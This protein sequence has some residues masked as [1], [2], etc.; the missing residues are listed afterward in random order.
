MLG[1]L[2]P[3]P[4]SPRVGVREST[5]ISFAKG[6]GC[7]CILEGERRVCPLLSRRFAE[8][9]YSETIRK[10]MGGTLHGLFS[11]PRIVNEP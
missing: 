5:G 7:E 9:A 11:R 3:A 10:R 8:V 4:G 6:R 1:P 2:V